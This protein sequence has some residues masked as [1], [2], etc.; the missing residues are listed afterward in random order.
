[1]CA[2]V[3]VA[4]VVVVRS[5]DRP[6]LKRRLQTM[7]HQ[8]TGLDVDWTA[9][10]V[11]LF[12]G[13]RID[14][15]VVATPPALRGE[16]PEL[17]RADG[18]AVTWT[19]RSLVVG[20]PRFGA[21]TVDALD[22]TLVRDGEGR[23]SLSTIEPHES[24]P[25]APPV[26][27]SGSAADALS[28][29]PP[30][31]RV[32]LGRVHVA[33]VERTPDGQR[34]R[35]DVDGLALGLALAGDGAGFRVAL[36]L[37]APER[38]L[39]LHVAR[40]RGGRPAG[41]AEAKLWAAVD[42]SAAAATARLD[43]EV[44]SQTLAPATAVKRALHL[45][46][47]AR[48]DRGAH[49]T[50]VTVARTRAADGAATMEAT[51]E[52]PDEG[53]PLVRHADGTIDGARLL[54]LVPAAL[55]PATVD[56]ARI[57]Y[58][59]DGL[60][61]A[62]PP[63]LLPG[64]SAKIDAT[65]GTV[66][67]PL[68]AG[69]L[70]VDG[71]HL[72]A[73]AQPG[74]RGATVVHAALPIDSVRL[75]G[76]AIA[77][78][79]LRLTAD[80]T[81]AADGAVGGDVAVAFAS[82]QKGG[83]APVSVRDGRLGVHA[84][85]L[86]VDAAAPLATRGALAVTF[87]AASVDARAGDTRVAAT[88]PGLSAR[89][90][91]RGQPPYAVD[92]ELP[93]ERLRV[94]GAG[95]RTL[96]DGAAR[97]A[98]HATDLLP[99][100]ARPLRTRGKVQ[101]ALA[102]GALD[103]HF[104]ADK[105]PD[106]VQFHVTARAPTLALVEPLLPARAAHDVGWSK[107]ALAL[108]TDG[109]VERLASASPSLQEHTQLSLDHL[110]ARRATGPSVAVERLELETHS[111]GTVP[112]HQG[113]LALR[114]R[115][116]QLADGAPGDRHVDLSWSVDAAAPSV[117]LTLDGGGAAGPILALEA[118]L[119]FDR[120]RR[121]VTY[122]LDSHVAKLASLAPLMSPGAAGFDFDTLDVTFR[123]KGSMAGLVRDIDAAG[124]VRMQPDPLATL[125]ADG[126]LDAV[127]AGLAWSGG[128][129]ELSVPKA[130]WHA[131]LASDGDR[132]L[133]HGTLDADSLELAV[134][135]HEI[136]IGGIRDD[137]DASIGGDLRF[138]VAELNHRLAVRSVTQAFAPGYRVG[139]VTLD[140]KA[141][142]DKDGIV[143]IAELRLDNRAAGT[144]FSVHG[145]LD[146]GRER[147]SLTLR[148]ELTQDLGKL[149]AVPQELAARG[150]ASLQLK[151][152]SGDLRVFHAQL[153][154]H[155]RGATVKSPRAGVA[156]TSLDGEIPVGADVVLDAE[157]AR[158][159]RSSRV[160]AYSELRFADQQP[161]QARHSF[162]TVEHVDTPFA[163]FGPIAGNLRID[164]NVVSLSQLEMG[165][166]GGR[167]TGQCIFSW[168]RDDSTVQLRVRASDVRSSHGEPFDG[169][170]AVVIS[171]GQRSIEGRAEILRI[172]RRHLLDL[173]NLQDPHH[174]DE[175]M[176]RIR[177]ALA[178]G[179]PKHV[180]LAFN[181]GFA[182]VKIELGG[183]ARL[184]SIDELRGIPMG[185]LIDKA[186]APLQRKEEEEP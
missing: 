146:A 81:V 134:G 169:N 182:N 184:I 140:I 36:A 104:D 61:A 83:A 40:A 78:D 114:A 16:A 162:I 57:D 77:G 109:R 177:R 115:S 66:R 101:L 121:A 43:V 20:T 8:K 113:K 155:L 174:A 42:A 6:W 153:A 170:S 65:L 70:A 28:G 100:A 47:D 102:V 126:T 97:V 32:D 72:T 145:G 33:L 53:A 142:R 56:R 176:N 125:A 1:M 45:E 156:I 147:R 144:S 122:D 183:L 172:G 91:L 98:L 117:H 60:Y 34:E 75:G 68:P 50:T 160:N 64:G 38:P 151:L 141:R 94:V 173:L 154:L 17:L 179:Y 118:T 22:L 21:L 136:D 166:R 158:L 24:G 107:M 12:S 95:S 159:L 93:V 99:D 5:L 74:E 152:D 29:P 49:R 164:N 4:L 161:L 67:A 88:Q 119:G 157:G 167:V 127:V 116:L 96:V 11:S 35:L 69:A 139:G 62:A 82:L 48:F 132:R 92:A 13:L 87:A 85:E 110:S 181:H 76:A 73:T 175:G 63:H 19:L 18:L 44:R 23:T 124:H 89:A 178:L 180:R 112:H 55:V 149:W 105:Q 3:V 71:A 80:A 46:A 129:R 163:S 185:P 165:L 7:A 123:G 111:A 37:G 10:H 128:D 84:D 14:R 133:V 41:E 27:I 108:T 15:L 137:I 150:S 171:T 26:P 59:I 138:G 58:R 86:R 52:L 103:A 106:A 30:I 120:A 130:H 90:Q 31:G 143:H 131:V 186:L 148:G 9:T 39:A 135:S 2:L 54:S 25:P 168:D 79:K 51:L